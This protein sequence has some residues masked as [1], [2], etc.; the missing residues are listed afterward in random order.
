MIEGITFLG[1]S[2][3]TPTRTRNVTSIAVHLRTG[4]TLLIDC[5]E[6][7]QHQLRRTTSATSPAARIGKIDGIFVTHLHG[8]HVFGLPGLLASISLASTRTAQHPPFVIAGPVGIRGFVETSISTSGTHITFPIRFVELDSSSRPPREGIPIEMMTAAGST[9][10]PLGVRAFPISHGEMACFGFVLSEPEK[11]GALDAAKA[12]TFGIRGKEL[13]MLKAGKVVTAPDGR[14]VAPSDVIGPP[15]PGRKVVI[16]GD[17]SDPG[18]LL[19]EAA[20]GCCAI[21]HESTFAEGEEEKAKIGGHS[22]SK[23]AGEFARRV[24]AGMLFLTHFSQRHE[25][26]DSVSSPAPTAAAAGSGGTAELAK[27]ASGVFQ[28]EVICAEEL[29]TYKLPQ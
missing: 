26:D 3:G 14:Q 9:D 11:A 25:D 23:M 29:K 18:D 16:L 21:V 6:G 5:G 27:Q 20:T 10:Q 7:T 12:A 19:A 24:R 4:R 1:T 28:G 8:D 15:K 2:A 13:G 22:T 17:T